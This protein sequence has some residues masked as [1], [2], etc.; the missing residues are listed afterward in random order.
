MT[1]FGPD[2]AECSVCE[3]AEQCAVGKS[4][5]SWVGPDYREGGLMIVGEGPGAKEVQIGQPFVGPAGRLLNALL[6]SVDYDRNACWLT[7]ATLC[8]PP[9]AP[10]KEQAKSSL[11]DR[12]PTAI[13]ACLPRLE[14][15]IM[16]ARPRVIL[17][18]GQAAL[19]ALTGYELHKTKLVNFACD[20]DPVTRGLGAGFE[21]ALGD[22]S[23][24]ELCPTEDYKSDSA[25]AWR[26]ALID[27]YGG[28]CPNCQSN[29]KKLQIKKSIKCRLCGGRKRREEQFTTFEHDYPLIGREGVAG[30]VFRTEALP[31]RLDEFGVK[32]VVPTYHPSFCLRTVSKDK[33]GGANK[34]IGGQYAA[35]ASTAHIQKAIELLRRDAVNFDVNPLISN[36][37][38]VVKKWLAA[39]GTYSVDIE[40][41]SYDG[42]YN[43]SLITCI[44]FSRV[45]RMQSLV[46]DGRNYKDLATKNWGVGDPLLDVIQEFLLDETKMKVFWNG[47][48]DRIG[49][50]LLWGMDVAGP[51]R[52]GMVAHNVLYPDEEHGLGFAAHELTDA[53]AWKPQHKKPPKGTLHALSGYGTFEALA[54]YNAKD[55]RLTVL[56]DEKMCGADGQHGLLSVEGAGL[57]T[58][59]EVDL[60]MTEVAFEMQ[61][62]GLP[63]NDNAREKVR[64]ENAEH[65]DTAL[66]K[67]RKIAGRDDYSPTGK[68]LEW[69]LYDPAG[70]CGFVVPRRTKTG[71]PGT[72]K[73]DLFKFGNHPFVQSLLMWRKHDYHRSHYIESDKLVTAFDGRIHPVW[74]PWGAR[75]GRW[76]SE[77]NFQNWPKYLRAMVLAPFGRRIVGADYSQ[78][79]LRIMAAMSGDPN[80]IRRCAE[81]DESDKLNPDKDPHAYMAERVFGSSYRD[82]YNQSANDKDGSD[83][84]KVLRDIVKRTVYGLNYGSGA[85][86]VLDA[87]YDGGYEGPPITLNIIKRVIDTYFTEFP[88]VP[89]WRDN[90]LRVA[91]QERRITS[92]ILG[93]HRIFPLG[94]VEATVAY[95]FPI[96]AG[97]AD[98]MNL[99]VWEVYRGLKDIDPT[100][101][102]IAQ[103]HD[104]IYAE[105][106]E[107][108]ANEVARFIEETLTVEWSLV[109][110]APKM[111]FVA[112]AAISENWKEAA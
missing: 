6:T 44:G 45:D 32:Y 35:R 23:W 18:L 12:F 86:T 95:N 43:C 103:V 77:P 112:S 16:E 101:V 2:L 41:D 108:R 68:A 55:T 24:F 20:C 31:S 90:I 42:I 38:K 54:K 62:A 29:I 48:Y 74:K 53:P 71:K 66:A 104:A 19:I 27:K 105:C 79:E 70:P 97:A 39:P 99:R 93:R 109:A 92:P 50:R 81:A 10:G 34:R 64:K 57:H 3:L 72:A 1:T 96:Q 46:V 25:K 40:T 8:Y 7:N 76:S 91:T 15:E 13:Y 60:Q 21:C 56:T 67:M 94:Q 36:D 63:L 33:L 51:V 88:G 59:H 102:L 17:T 100:A 30:A 14:A 58:V 111:P 28:V 65:V 83:R 107:A 4:C 69:A 80:L 26:T 49:L 78:L 84:C 106:D 5:T 98:I 110:G 82:A 89:S 52:D 47:N 61:W 11:N 37:P 22:C 87:I 9:F 75:T 85:Q 73:E